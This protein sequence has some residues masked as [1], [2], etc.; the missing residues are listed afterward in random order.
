MQIKMK[1]LKINTSTSN[2]H[3]IFLSEIKRAGGPY[4]NKQKVQ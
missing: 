2:N 1:A 3:R 4:A